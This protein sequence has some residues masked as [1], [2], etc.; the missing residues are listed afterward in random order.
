MSEPEVGSAEARELWRRWQAAGAVAPTTDRDF[1]TLVALAEDRAGPA[2][3]RR[4]EELLVA[5][6]GLAEDLAAIANP[7]E[8][9]VDDALLAAIAAR[10]AALVPA[11][12]ARILPFRGRRPGGGTGARWYE[13]ARW[14]ALAASIALIGYL[15][16]A[17]GGTAYAD[18]ASLTSDSLGQELLDPSTGFLGGL[19]SIANDQAGI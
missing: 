18:F 15:G 11:E 3:R 14:G 13:P 8:G 9:A 7:P 5:D 17:L 6:P 1:V 4:F 10:A 19:T 2:E 12:T 16:F